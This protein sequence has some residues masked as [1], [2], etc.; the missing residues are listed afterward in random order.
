MTTI[1]RLLVGLSLDHLGA[2]SGEG[3]QGAAGLVDAAVR[4]D[5]LGFDLLVLDDA[6][7]RAGD[8][9]PWL[10]A[11][12]ALAFV[13][14]RTRRIGLVATAASHYAEPFHLAKAIAT[15]DFISGGRAGVL[16]EP[17]RSEAADRFFP[18]AR[19][20]D[21]FERDAEA[22]EFV[23]VV[24]DL[25]DSWEDGAEIRD[26]VTGRYVDNTKVHHID[27]DGPYFRVK[28]PLI[29]PRPPQGRPPVFL[30]DH[31]AA[32]R[33]IPTSPGD[34]AVELV[35]LRVD[36]A[37]ELARALAA[38]APGTSTGARD[39][40]GSAPETT[41]MLFV[42]EPRRIDTVLA[43]L[44]ASRIA[45]PGVRAAA[46]TRLATRL[47]QRWIPSRFAARP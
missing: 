10:S 40:S 45:L 17:S 2:D 24:G 32:T 22:A 39:G 27:H 34:P 18:A 7:S 21:P 5:E 6:L 43:E 11:I 25:W 38:G 46:G 41:V 3:A 13:A 29:T 33:L 16:I 14:R 15:V 44:A 30:T 36:S 47:G 8:D 37:D 20:L 28:G 35:R 4:A 42:V 9:L 19:E 23:S 1:Q 26:T 12:D 31:A